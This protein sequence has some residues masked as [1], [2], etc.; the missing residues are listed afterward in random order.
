M[1]K[2]DIIKEF[3]NLR[4]AMLEERRKL[5]LR[6]AEIDA[7]LNLATPPSAKRVLGPRPTNSM[8][9][10][11]AIEKVL[12]K[13]AL[14]IR[15]IVTELNGIGYKF[16]S[17]NPV[18]SLGAYLYGAGKSHFRRKNGRFLNA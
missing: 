5:A 2:Q 8:T 1:P 6:M 11:E 18:N 3:S 10:R 15:E 16:S 13:R 12:K 14:S 4:D 9:M 7:A 17:K